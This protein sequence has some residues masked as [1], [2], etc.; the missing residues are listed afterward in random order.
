M[1]SD[2]SLATTLRALTDDD[3]EP[4]AHQVLSVEFDDSNH[5]APRGR[6]LR[7]QPGVTAGQAFITTALH[8]WSM[9]EEYEEC[10][11]PL[12]REIVME[13]LGTRSSWNPVSLFRAV[14]LLM[15]LA[16]EN[17]G[18]VMGGQ[19]QL[20]LFDALDELG[21]FTR[22]AVGLGCSPLLVYEF[23]RGWVLLE[24]S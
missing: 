23:V 21:P 19:K 10:D 16:A 8:H 5:D 20:Q 3:L 18:P 12:R 22:G 2:S 14:W 6:M 1:S 9:L 4:V 17:D 11:A 13:D 7:W 24:V 15:R